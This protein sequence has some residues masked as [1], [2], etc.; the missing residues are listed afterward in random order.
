MAVKCLVEVTLCRQSDSFDPSKFGTKRGG[1]KRVDNALGL[2]QAW[3]ESP[4]TVRVV[5]INLG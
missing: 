4:N 3:I 2:A 5:G 1:F